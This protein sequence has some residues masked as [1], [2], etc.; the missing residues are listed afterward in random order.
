VEQLRQTVA[1]LLVTDNAE[2]KAAGREAV[3]VN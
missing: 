3:A 2:A 1:P